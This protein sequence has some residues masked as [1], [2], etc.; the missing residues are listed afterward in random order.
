MRR[1]LVTGASSG[2]GRALVKALALRGDLVWGVARR[3]DKLAELQRE[4]SPKQFLSTQC[5]V[6][7][8]SQIAETVRF[9]RAHPFVPD[10]VVLNAGINTQDLL[11]HYDHQR[12]LDVMQTN[13]FGVMG[14]VTELL[15]LYEERGEGHFIA[16]SSMSAFL[17]H[18][19]G[20]AYGASKAAL[21]STFE[22]LRKRYANTRIKFTTVHLGPVNTAMWSGRW[23]PLLLSEEAVARKLMVAMERKPAVVDYPCGLVWAARL[24]QFLPV[25]IG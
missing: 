1:V 25:K 10:V 24:S 7:Q 21:T 22:S 12:Y 6:T 2:I 20:A 19:R 5:D 4:L 14:W 18:G 8:P 3:I 11:P 15:P 9:M 17:T 16:I 13:L 23:F